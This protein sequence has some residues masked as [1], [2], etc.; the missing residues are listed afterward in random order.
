[1][2][3]KAT[4]IYFLCGQNRCR[5][6]IAEAFA[7]YYGG[8]HVVVESAGLEPPNTLHPFTIEVMQEVGI[9]LSQNVSKK[10]DMKFFISAN[11]IVKLCEQV[12]ERCPIVPFHIRNE[13]WNITDPLAIEGC[14]LQDVRAARDEIREKVI[15]LLKGMNIPVV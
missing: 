5:S 6:Q 2:N 13:E 12:V 7:K 11:A 10:I 4:R 1:M 14:T 15:G 8:E 3:S 9:D